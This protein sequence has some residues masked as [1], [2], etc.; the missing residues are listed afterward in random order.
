MGGLPRG[1]IDSHLWVG[2]QLES[3]FEQNSFFEQ[4]L[5]GEAQAAFG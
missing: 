1:R 2:F 4:S 3:S 5:I